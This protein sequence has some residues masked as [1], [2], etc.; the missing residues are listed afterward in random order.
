MQEYEILLDNR[1]Y[2]C[3]SQFYC[4]NLGNPT[5]ENK[6]DALGVDYVSSD[7]VIR[8]FHRFIN[9]EQAGLQVK[10]LVDISTM[11]G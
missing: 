5:G 4:S 8:S 2:G 11:V 3:S 7:V 10:Y 9:M 1:A 6:K